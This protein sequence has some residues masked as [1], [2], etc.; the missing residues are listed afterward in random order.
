M[1]K[2]VYSFNADALDGLIFYWKK[3]SLN[4]NFF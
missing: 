2:I 4:N 1:P 3:I